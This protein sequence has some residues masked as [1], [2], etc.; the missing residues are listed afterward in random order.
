[1]SA[2]NANLQALQTA[3][4]L[5]CNQDLMNDSLNRLSSGSKMI[6]V[7]DNPVGAG[8]A[9]DMTSQNQR[10]T[11]AATN[12]QNAVSYTQT[13]SDILSAVG[14]VLE[15]MSEIATLVQGTTQNSSDVGGYQTEFQGLQDQLRNTIGGTTAEIGGTSDVSSPLGSFDGIALFGAN[16]SGYQVVLGASA[17]ESMTIPATNLQTGAMLGLIQQDSSGNYTVNI[18]SVSATDLTS[19]IQQVAQDQSSLGAAQERLDL[20]S[21]TVQTQSQ[22]LGS[23]ISQINDV[24]VASQSTALAT[25]NVLVQ[26]DAAMLAQANSMSAAALKLLKN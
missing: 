19:A 18:S 20:A 24:D 11:A 7:A 6:S 25:Y 16:P 13:G 1:M 12:I 26:A 23:A 5:G 2:I 3:A 9:G 8:I 22:N 10:L 4:A 17:G 21:S 14:S 15:R